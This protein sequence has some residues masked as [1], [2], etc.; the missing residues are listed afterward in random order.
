MGWSEA[1]A[2]CCAFSTVA[3]FLKPSST[4]FLHTLSSLT[5]EFLPE[6]SVGD[7]YRQKEASTVAEHAPTKMMMMTTRIF[8]VIALNH[9][10]RRLSL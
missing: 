1:T 2:A 5:D 4:S 6:S 10:E 7:K 8:H 3:C 9:V